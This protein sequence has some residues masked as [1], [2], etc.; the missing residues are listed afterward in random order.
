MTPIR[1]ALAA[2]LAGLIPAARAGDPAP[3]SAP[4]SIRAAL[5]EAVALARA[6]GLP[7]DANHDVTEGKDSAGRP[8]LFIGERIAE[9]L[10][11]RGAVFGKFPDGGVFFVDGEERQRF[12]MTRVSR[13]LNRRERRAA[14]A[15]HNREVIRDRVARTKEATRKA[16]AKTAAAG[17]I[18]R[19][20]ARQAGPDGVV[21]DIDAEGNATT[22]PLGAVL[23]KME[24]DAARR[25]R[26]SVVDDVAAVIR[27]G[28]ARG[29]STEEVRGH[30]APLLAGL[31]SGRGLVLGIDPTPG[32]DGTG[33]AIVDRETRKVVNA[34]FVPSKGTHG[35]A[36]LDDDAAKLLA[37]GQDPGPTLEELF[38]Q[39][40]RGTTVIPADHKPPAGASE[41]YFAADEKEAA[42]L[43]ARFEARHKGPGPELGRLTLDAS[44]LS[45]VVAAPDVCPS[46]GG[47][48]AP[49]DDGSGGRVLG[50][51]R[52]GNT[53]EDED[54]C[55]WHAPIV[56]VDAGEEGQGA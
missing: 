40:L 2:V 18:A 48:V 23:E 34:G 30:V 13:P 43:R 38:G 39:P 47:P 42:E 25:V 9:D 49:F 56:D 41:I 1:P 14:A 20:R 32:K 27:D 15:S 12:A 17:T 44:K 37:F 5:L 51:T 26:D 11:R 16:K 50:C 7:V 53:P 54:G 46:C 19:V 36:A 28:V 35:S 6:E 45:A 52:P 22:L 31:T 10:R 21:I 33:W 24:K 29:L 3:V 4:Q 55:G 8:C